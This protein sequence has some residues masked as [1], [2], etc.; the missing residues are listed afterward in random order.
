VTPQ[1]ALIATGADGN[2]AA[3]SRIG[4]FARGL[5]RR[6]WSVRVTDPGR[7]YA[8]PLERLL[9]HAPMPVRRTLEHV[10]VE[11]D[12]RPA[13]GWRARTAV[14]AVNT[15]VTVVSVPPFSLLGTVALTLDPRVPPRRR[16]PR[17]VERAP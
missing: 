1:V 7:P 5:A 2:G 15:D 13:T 10:G 12:V 11:G 8:T 4:A 17:P 16:L 9:E 14:R 3:G 6:G